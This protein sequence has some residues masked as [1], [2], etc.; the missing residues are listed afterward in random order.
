[1]MDAPFSMFA[2]AV[3]WT[4]ALSC[5]SS[6]TRVASLSLRV[7]AAP[8]VRACVA[9]S[10]SARSLVALVTV[11]SGGS[12]V[13]KLALPVIAV[14]IAWASLMSS[15]TL[16]GSLRVTTARLIRFGVLMEPHLLGR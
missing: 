16:R 8:R 5:S 10:A 9:V 4:Y 1:M 14:T 7:A 13:P 2:S 12:G 15:G 3:F 6:W 11:A